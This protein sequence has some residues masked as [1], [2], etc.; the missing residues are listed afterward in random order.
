MAEQE[1]LRTELPTFSFLHPVG[2][3]TQQLH[4]YPVKFCKEKQF[5]DWILA[6]MLMI[7]QTPK[8]FPGGSLLKN[9]PANAGVLGLIP[10]SVRFP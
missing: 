2:K 9:P 8:G 7:W 6:L 4:A 3:S 5:V 10:G 1:R